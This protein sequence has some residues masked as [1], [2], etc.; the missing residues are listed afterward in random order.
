M[1]H[2]GGVCMTAAHRGE[3]FGYKLAAELLIWESR[4]ETR[5]AEQ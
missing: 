2:Q 1:K 5:E 3:T 4:Q